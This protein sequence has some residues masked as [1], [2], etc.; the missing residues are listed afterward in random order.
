[1]AFAVASELLSSGKSFQ[2]VTVENLVRGNEFS[3]S[4]MSLMFQAIA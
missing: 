1:M 3:L 2:Q 4:V